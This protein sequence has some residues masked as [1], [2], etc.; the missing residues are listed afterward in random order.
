M[1]AQNA[2]ETA[3]LAAPFDEGDEVDALGDQLPGHDRDRFLNETFDPVKRGER[4]IGVY[5]RDA[6]GMAGI[7]GLE[8]VER[9]ARRGHDQRFVGSRLIKWH[10]L[11]R[12]Q[13]KACCRDLARHDGIAVD[14]WQQVVDSVHR[15][16]QI[17]AEISHASGEQSRGIAAIG[18]KVGHMEQSTQQN[19]AL[20]EQA[21]AATR[22][23]QDQ[24]AQ[25]ADIVGGFR[26]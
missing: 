3:R 12:P 1:D 24:S 13:D 17:V 6:A 20:V 2:G 5:G 10:S 16:T 18:S 14:D 9:D 8:H 15:V 7:P 19:A 11:F 21:A 4:A 25:L 23:L 26:L 22:A